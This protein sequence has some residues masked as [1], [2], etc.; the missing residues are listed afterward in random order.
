MQ[1][2]NPRNQGFNIDEPLSPPD[3]SPDEEKSGGRQIPLLILVL[4][5]ILLLGS[6]AVLFL[7]PAPKPEPTSVSQQKTNQQ[8]VFR[9]EPDA[10]LSDEQD[11]LQIS[12]HNDA[13]VAREEAVSLKISANSQNIA[14]W[15]G[16]GYHSIIQMF[17]E[18]D[19][20]FNQQD[21][22]SATEHYQQVSGNLQ[23]LLDSRPLLLK[24]ALETGQRALL[25]ED[26][27]QAQ[28]HF[29]LALAIDP[30]SREARTGLENSEL[31]SSVLSLYQKALS[32]EQEGKLEEAV[33]ELQYV[34]DLDNSHDPALQASKRIQNRIDERT[35]QNE[36][37]VLLSALDKLDF[38]SAKQSLLALKSLGINKEQIEQAADLLAEKE[39]LVFV[40]SSRNAAETYKQNEQWQ[41]ALETYD[42]ILSIAPEALF[43]S[44]GKKEAAKRLKLDVSLIDAIGRPH[45]LHDEK[46]R[47]QAAQLL[48]YAEQVS[49]RGAKLQSQIESLDSLLKQ[50]QTP[51]PVILESD[52]Q[53]DIAIYHLGRIGSFFSKEI[54]LKPGT[55]TVV[56]SKV[57]Y[58]DVRKII[59]IES[60]GGDY[61][62]T[63]R[64]EEPI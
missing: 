41:Q 9:P 37:N 24:Q 5:V 15:G 38:S 50:A 18:A 16:T 36:M 52:N 44:A 58:R 4:F 48:T 32:L 23:E 60:S 46:Q 33:A 30:S 54:L 6:A 7:L 39:Q 31:L 34:L 40:A 43:A 1:S 17:T 8:P 56:G 2:G 59:R 12:A 29:K 63:I 35:F 22:Q 25:D 11:S 13:A 51:V 27:V 21:Y 55:Y 26:P 28:D 64:C 53:T 19:E 42:K 10:V 62:F 3:S 45:R 47:E 20:R 57:G 49:P 14:E 61:R